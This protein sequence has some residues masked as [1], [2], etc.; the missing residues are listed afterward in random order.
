LYTNADGTFVALNAELW[1]IQLQKII[2]V[3]DL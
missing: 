3:E 2:I 1:L